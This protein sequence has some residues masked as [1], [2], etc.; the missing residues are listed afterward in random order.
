[1]SE[2]LNLITNDKENNILNEIIT[3]AKNISFELCMNSKPLTPIMEKA[4]T[5]VS[6]PI[7]KLYQYDTGEKTGNNSQP[8]WEKWIESFQQQQYEMVHQASYA[9]YLLGLSYL[10][11]SWEQFPPGKKIFDWYIS[12]PKNAEFAQ[13][14]IREA[15]EN[16]NKVHAPGL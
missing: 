1:M 2:T 5:L 4:Y 8:G 7:C 3:L 11:K 10:V 12:N 6:Q 14:R 13:I 16:L 9:D 15:R